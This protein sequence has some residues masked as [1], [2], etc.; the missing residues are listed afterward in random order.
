MAAC[1]VVIAAE[2]R[3]GRVVSPVS[4]R[5]PR[6]RGPRGRTRRKALRHPP[7]SLT[8]SGTCERAHA[9]SRLRPSSSTAPARAGS[10]GWPPAGSHAYGPANQL[11]I[12][13]QKPEATGVAGFRAWLKWLGHRAFLEAAEGTRTLD[14]LHGKQT[15]IARSD[16]FIPAYHPHRRLRRAGDCL[17]FRRFWLE[18]WHPMGTETR[19]R[20]DVAG[21]WPF[22]RCVELD[23]PGRC[24]SRTAAITSAGLLGLDRDRARRPVA[25][26]EGP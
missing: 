2:G 18:F 24:C 12:V 23:A 8:R 11:L 19:V 9:R 16:R 3:P 13:I 26:C 4:N 25:G 17:R 10:S 21:A 20:A 6:G 14:L 5:R 22:P 15:L 1:S 7:A